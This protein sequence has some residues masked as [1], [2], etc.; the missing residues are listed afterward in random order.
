LYE[1][2]GDDLLFF[3]AVIS[4]SSVIPNKFVSD[5]V[6]IPDEGLR[7]GTGEE[8]FTSCVCQDFGACGE[9]TCGEGLGACGKSIGVCN[10]GLSARDEGF[11]TNG[12]GIIGFTGC[13][14]VG[15]DCPLAVIELGSIKK[16][17]MR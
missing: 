15:V 8:G 7:G 6:G 11:G 12:K 4:S 5:K 9:S 14:M 2:F 10:E 13:M 3:D 17:H 1:D 16:R